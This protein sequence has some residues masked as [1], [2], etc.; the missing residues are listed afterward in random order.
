MVGE[1]GVAQNACGAALLVQILPQLHRVLAVVEAP[2]EAAGRGETVHTAADLHR[3]EQNIVQ[4][5]RV[6]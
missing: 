3:T 4:Y 6:G 5:I 2:A 1:S